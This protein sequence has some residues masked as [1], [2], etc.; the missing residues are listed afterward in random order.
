[1]GGEQVTSFEAVEGGGDIHI[2][3]ATGVKPGMIS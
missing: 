3:G 1:M 2:A